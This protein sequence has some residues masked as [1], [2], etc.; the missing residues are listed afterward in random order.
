MKI[1]VKRNSNVLSV[2]SDDIAENS[3]EFRLWRLAWV[4]PLVLLIAFVAGMMLES[5][6]HWF[7]AWFSVP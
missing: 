5:N 6:V 7:Y 3:H 1:V 2:L 4:S